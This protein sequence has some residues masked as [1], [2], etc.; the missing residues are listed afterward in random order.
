[1]YK[2]FDLAIIGSSF[3]GLLIANALKNLN[4]KI[5]LIEKNKLIIKPN[6]TKRTTAISAGNARFLQHIGL[7]QDCFAQTGKILNIRIQEEHSGFPINYNHQERPMCYVFDNQFLL[8]SLYNNLQNSNINFFLNKNFTNIATDNYWTYI[9]LEDNFQIQTSL[10]I[11]ADGKF[12]TVRDKLKIPIYEKHYHQSALIFNIY[13]E[14]KHENNA[15]ELFTTQGPLALLPTFDQHQSSVIWTLENDIAASY[16]KLEQSIIAAFLSEKINHHLGKISI[17]SEIAH[18]PLSLSYAKKYFHKR[19]LF[20]GDALHSIH[21]IAGQGLNLSIQDV[22][23]LHE[24]ITAHHALGYDLGNEFL[25]NKFIQK[26]KHKNWQMI[27]ITDK[28]NS[29]YCNQNILLKY[30]KNFGSS[31]IDSCDLLKKNLINYAMQM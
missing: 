22:K 8:Q 2:K 28:L 1:M 20:M 19:V 15:L 12:S 13:H 24:I 4:L 9:D 14:K 7:T 17:N 21:P 16:I 27:Q 26:R 31:L 18:H 25:L 6:P 29:L 10:L 11:A 3:I 5:A 30:S 23:M